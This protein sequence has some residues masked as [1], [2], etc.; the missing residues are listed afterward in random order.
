MWGFYRIPDMREYARIHLRLVTLAGPGGH[1]AKSTT[2]LDRYPLRRLRL[3]ACRRAAGGS[4]VPEWFERRR[5]QLAAAIRT[6][7]EAGQQ[8]THPRF[9][10]P[11][12]PHGQT[13]DCP[14]GL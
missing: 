5:W 12:R 2:S 13:I 7:P 9:R 10:L 3:P 14:A 4:G 6:T 11:S 1:L 8:A